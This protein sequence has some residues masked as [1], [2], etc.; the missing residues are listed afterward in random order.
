MAEYREA[1]RIRPDYLEAHANLL[2]AEMPGRTPEALAEYQAALRINPVS[3]EVHYDL[4][5]ALLRTGRRAEAI[6]Q[7]EAALSARPDV[8]PVK[9]LLG[10]LKAGR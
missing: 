2:L 6:A 9:E 10:R 5:Q 7:L 1:L 3:P 4:A 8:E